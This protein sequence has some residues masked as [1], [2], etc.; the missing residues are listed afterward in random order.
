MGLLYCFFCVFICLVTDTKHY[1]AKCINSGDEIV[2]INGHN[3]KDKSLQE[4]QAM[5]VN[6][7]EMTPALTEELNVM[8][9]AENLIHVA[10]PDFMEPK[11]AETVYLR[12]C[13]LFSV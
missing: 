4:I 2:A 9:S 6:L 7:P 3:V 13:W 1:A 12:F 11:P 5:L 8:G 10:E